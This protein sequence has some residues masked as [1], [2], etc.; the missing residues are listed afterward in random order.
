MFSDL[1]VLSDL[2]TKLSWHQ[3]RQN[4]L[5]ENV[6][7]ADT[8]GFRGRDLKTPDFER[9]LKLAM[10]QPVSTTVTSPMHVSV[11][12]SAP[13]NSPRT[14]SGDG[15]EV[16]PERNNVVLEEQ[17]MKVAENQME[18]QAASTLYSRALGVFRIAVGN[19]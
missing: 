9:S 2:K 7:N 18:F 6:A 19:R 14:D 15:W 1:P 12:S 5:A 16:T 13:M 8:P 4:V 3:S 11:T 17:M 10:A